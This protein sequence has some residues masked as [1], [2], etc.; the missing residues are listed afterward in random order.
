MQRF[1][2]QKLPD[3]KYNVTIRRQVQNRHIEGTIE[4]NNY[5][6]KLKDS[7]IKPGVLAKDI[8]AAELINKFHKQGIYDPNPRDN[9]PREIVDVGK[10]VGKYWN[11]V[12]GQYND[13]RFIEIVYS[14]A[15]AHIYPVRPPKGADDNEISGKI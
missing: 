6:Q 9:S 8:D 7:G 4:F 10:V 3:V 2:T 15:G 14:K 13:T 12:T 1:S 11:T 5:V